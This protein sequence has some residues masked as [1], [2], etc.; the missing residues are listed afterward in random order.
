M[1][2]IFHDRVQVAKTRAALFTASELKSQR[3]KQ[4]KTSKIYPITA[5]KVNGAVSKDPHEWAENGA[6]EFNHRWTQS[7]EDD[8]LLF[9][10]F[11]GAK[12]GFVSVLVLLVCFVTNC[13]PRCHLVANL[14]D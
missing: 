6:I 14:L 2:K 13:R 4:K 5:M 3:S 1:R 7:S 11:E 9:N 12:D 8:Q 10:A